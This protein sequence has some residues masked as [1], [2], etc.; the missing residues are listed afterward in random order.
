MFSKILFQDVKGHCIIFLIKKGML[1]L[2]DITTNVL[3]DLRMWHSP[4][5]NIL[6]L[7]LS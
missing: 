7:D 1:G 3:N 4:L 6:R 5:F 2:I